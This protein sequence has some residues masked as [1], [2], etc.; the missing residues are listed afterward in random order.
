MCIDADAEFEY[1]P[2]YDDQDCTYQVYPM[3][4]ENMP[5]Y[6]ARKPCGCMVYMVVDDPAD[7]EDKAKCRDKAIEI[8]KLLRDGLTIERVTVGVARADKTFL[9]CQ[10]DKPREATGESIRQKS[11]I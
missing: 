8:S 9:N 3:A 5:A 11:L 10:H 4:N 7:A 2:Y 6:V 1:D